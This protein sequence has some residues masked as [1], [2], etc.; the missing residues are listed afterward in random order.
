[1]S[2]VRVRDNQRL[3]VRSA[4]S[5]RKTGSSLFNK[6]F[7]LL[8]DVARKQAPEEAVDIGKERSKRADCGADPGNRIDLG[9]LGGELAARGCGHRGWVDD[10]RV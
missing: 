2:R 3:W 10:D 6:A 8:L 1:M 4:L 7:L 9:R 5:K